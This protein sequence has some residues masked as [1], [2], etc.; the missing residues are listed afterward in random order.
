MCDVNHI[1]FWNIITVVNVVLFADF[2]NHNNVFFKSNRLSINIIFVPWARRW[3]RPQNR[4]T[5]IL[6]FMAI[7]NMFIVEI[8]PIYTSVT[9]QVRTVCENN[10]KLAEIYVEITLILR[11]S[12]IRLWY[13]RAMRS[14]LYDTYGDIFSYCLRGR[15]V[16]RHTNHTVPSL[17]LHS[18][19]IHYWM[20]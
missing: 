15:S 12:V 18:T 8:R 1:I 3:R 16:Y 2:T 10:F 19:Y 7:S 17:L 4:I 5:I 20:M 14:S 11:Y 9:P 13:F 6:K